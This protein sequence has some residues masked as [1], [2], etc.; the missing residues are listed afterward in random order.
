MTQYA[1]RM[2]TLFVTTAFIASIAPTIATAVVEMARAAGGDTW[3]PFKY[4]IAASEDTLL[5]QIEHPWVPVAVLITPEGAQS[6][7]LYY[8][9]GGPFDSK[10]ACE[11]FVKDDEDFADT[12]NDLSD[13]ATLKLGDGAKVGVLCLPDPKG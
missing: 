11:T 8:R 7:K 4:S 6:Q 10:G 13:F 12:I 5:A 9:D 1:R 2:I 3:P